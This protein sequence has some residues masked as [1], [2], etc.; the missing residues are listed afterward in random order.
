MKKPNGYW[1]KERCK[2]ISSMYDNKSLFIK[3]QTTIYVII[4][5]NKW[6]DELC[7]HMVNKYH[8][9][10]TK[11]ECHVEALKYT[12]KIDFLKNNRGC[13][14]ASYE[15]K[16]L[17]DICSHMNQHRKPN[18]YWTKEKCT[19]EALKYDIKIDFKINSPGA[20]SVSKKNGW[21][22]QIRSHMTLI[23]DIYKR[24]IYVWEFED[25]SAYIGLSSNLKRRTINHKTSKKSPVFNHLL[26]YNGECKQITNYVDVKEAQEIEKNT[27][28]LYETNG[29]NVL[30]KTRGGEIGIPKTHRNKL[31][32]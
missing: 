29:W 5:R 31:K 28:K 16:W 17:D 20:Y 26:Y 14:S 24:C 4:R 9:K 13:Y 23:G 19:E 10:W 11:N 7:D 22:D 8:K 2:E 12:S 3:E 25:K 27:I 18:G 1:T 30:N 6:I 21:L 32:F 15:N